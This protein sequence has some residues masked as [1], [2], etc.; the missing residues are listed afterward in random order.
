M[1]GNGC[2]QTTRQRVGGFARSLDEEL[3]IEHLAIV[4]GVGREQ[5]IGHDG[6][7][8]EVAAGMGN[9]GGLRSAPRVAAIICSST[10]QRVGQAELA[11]GK[12]VSS[13]MVAW[14]FRCLGRKTL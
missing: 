1:P 8:P 14:R 10:R 3:F 12:R 11:N 5:G 4:L 6:E 2:D 13:V 9:R 7:G